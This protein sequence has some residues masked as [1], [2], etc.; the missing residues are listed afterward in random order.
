VAFIR[1]CDLL[2][3]DGSF[4]KVCLYPQIINCFPEDN[5]I[6]NIVNLVNENDGE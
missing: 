2:G 4:E 1:Y 5:P 3:I 6:Y